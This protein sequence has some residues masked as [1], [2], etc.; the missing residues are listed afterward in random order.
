MEAKLQ[1]IKQENEKLNALILKKSLKSNTAQGQ[2]HKQGQNVYSN[3]AN[4]QQ[5]FQYSTPDQ[6][7]PN[8]NMFQLPNMMPFNMSQPFGNQNM[9]L[10]FNNMFN[11]MMKPDA[12]SQN[13]ESYNGTNQKSQHD[14]R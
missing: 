14:S 1:K 12:N 3:Q 10:N 9:P 5:M 8:P 13:H 7:F 2:I 4:Q 11:M 6:G